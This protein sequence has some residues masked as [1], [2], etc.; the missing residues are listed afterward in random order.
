MRIM[1]PSITA[2]PAA[3]ADATV[4]R[5]ASHLFAASDSP[6][7][8]SHLAAA[9][10]RL[11]DV[12]GGLSLSNHHRTR[13]GAYAASFIAT[14]PTL[15]SVYP[16]LRLVS[17]R[18]PDIS[19][20][21]S[22]S[23]SL[24]CLRDELAAV[25]AAYASL[26]NATYYDVRGRELTDFHPHLSSQL[27]I[28]TLHE[29]FH[30]PES[31]I[32]LPSQARLTAVTRHSDWLSH[33][34]AC[35]AFDAAQTD[36]SLPPH[37]ETTRHI[38]AS[39]MGSGAYLQVTPDDAIK[40]SHVDDRT[41]LAAAQY[42]AG[43]H[44]TALK[45][46]L[47]C[48]ATLGEAVT[49]ADRL[50]DPS[51]N[52]RIKTK[53]HRH[54]AAVS[55][56]YT[57]IQAA[58]I[59][60][61]ILGDKG[62]GSHNGTAPAELKQRYSMYNDGYIP[63]IIATSASPSGSHVLYEVKCYTPFPGTR[64]LGRGSQANGGAASTVE[65]YHLAF[66]NTEERLLWQ[67]LGTQQRG[68][69]HQPPLDHATGYGYVATH[70]GHYADGLAKG[71]QVV[72]LISETLGGITPSAVRA[73]R[74]LHTTASPDTHRDGTVYGLARSATHSFFSHHLRLMS[75]AI[76]RQNMALLLAGADRAAQRC[77]WPSPSRSLSSAFADAAHGCAVSD[78]AA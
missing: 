16:P 73:L 19:T 37:R 77:L 38:S 78:E 35:S 67:I 3:A 1:D 62:D 31:Q 71:N 54:N 36:P 34:R 75:L 6:P 27:T 63:D 39:Q 40:G 22:A 30:D 25:S 17:L 72:P 11:R 18:N 14:N 51:I 53:T 58:A 64:R 57:A 20:F 4:S 28:P 56:W 8:R 52:D 47:D 2:A 26:D 46:A 55:A 5:A 15:T 60:P 68:Q 29:L 42:R 32:T 49:E 74:R 69:S 33:L 76:H 21:A 41:F 50:G 59:T 61:T 43:L 44:I 45:P 24:T 23:A 10:F 9:S 70:R 65:G 66:G 7:A 12:D 13:H 48:L